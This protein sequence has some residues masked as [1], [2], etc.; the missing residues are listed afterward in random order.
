MNLADREYLNASDL[1]D[2]L[3]VSILWVDK[4][5]SAHRIPGQKKVGKKWLFLK[6]VIDRRMKSGENFLLEKKKSK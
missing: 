2:Y 1:A 6:S 3:R 4:Q 5:S